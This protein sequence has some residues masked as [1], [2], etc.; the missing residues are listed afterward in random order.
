MSPGPRL[1][2]EMPN[3][4]SSSRRHRTRSSSRGTG[5]SVWC[6]SIR[7]GGGDRDFRRSDRRESPR[8]GRND[9]S[10]HHT[11]CERVSRRDR[12]PSVVVCQP[13]RSRD[14]RDRGSGLFDS[15]DRTRH[16]RDAR[17]SASSVGTS[18]GSREEVAGRQQ[19]FSWIPVHGE[20]KAAAPGEAPGRS[21]ADVYQRVTDLELI[22]A[23]NY[24]R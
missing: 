17:G 16:S 15:R 2:V 1:I 11:R 9:P 18:G 7:S 19:P 21:L 23:H 24:R 14:N 12:S 10:S 13:E 4:Y 8:R 5:S 20:T 3:H 22:H 6:S